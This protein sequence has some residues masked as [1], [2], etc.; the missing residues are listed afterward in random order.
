MGLANTT[1]WS[2]DFLLWQL[3]LSRGLQYQHA[4]LV[5]NGAET[6]PNDA[7]F[8]QEFEE[9]DNGNGHSGKN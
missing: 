7:G 9:L 6:Y 2:E 5:M 3:P 8:E 4:I 1:G